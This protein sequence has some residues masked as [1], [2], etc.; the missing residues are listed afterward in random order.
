MHLTVNNSQATLAVDERRLIAAA[1]AVLADAGIGAGSLSI[2]VVDD[3][4]MHRLNRQYLGHDYPTDV[5]SF[6]LE[7]RA[8]YLEGEV[9]VSADTAA[10]NAAQYGMPVL[11]E[12]LLY[13]IH[14]TLHLAGYRD[15]SDADTAQMRRAEQEYLRRFA[16]VALV[17]P[18]APGERSL[19]TGGE[20]RQ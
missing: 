6:P 5:L 11:D 9:I 12:L 1:A 14:G 16:Q 2:A 17:A 3:E 7:E 19:S 18:R 20:G 10:A 15:K 13:V 4:A 8:G